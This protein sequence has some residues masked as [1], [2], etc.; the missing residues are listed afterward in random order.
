MLFEQLKKVIKHLDT[1]NKQS[2]LKMI[3]DAGFIVGED[4]LQFIEVVSVVVVKNLCR[5]VLLLVDT[6]K[7]SEICGQEYQIMFEI[8]PQLVVSNLD[9]IQR[10]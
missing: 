7:M 2:V 8:S 4:E 5:V 10:M 9:Y 1:L 6:D 3:N